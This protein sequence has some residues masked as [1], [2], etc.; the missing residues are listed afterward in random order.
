V[1]TNLK[2]NDE[3]QITLPDVR[4]GNVKFVS[5]VAQARQFQ[6]TDFSLNHEW[7]VCVG[8]LCGDILWAV[9]RLPN[10]PGQ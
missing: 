10:F 5:V 1:E 7:L 8:C 2:C 4:V 9:E 6:C 3:Q